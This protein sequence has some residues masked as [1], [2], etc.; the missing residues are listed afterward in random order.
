MNIGTTIEMN[1]KARRKFDKFHNKIAQS[2]AD[3]VLPNTNTN[4]IEIFLNILCD[5]V[6]IE[7][8]LY[9]NSFACGKIAKHGRKKTHT[10]WNVLT[11]LRHITEPSLSPY[12]HTHTLTA[13]KRRA[14]KTIL[15]GLFVCF[16]VYE[17]I[18]VWAC[19]CVY[20]KI[21]CFSFIGLPAIKCA[22]LSLA[23]ILLSVSAR[24]RSFGFVVGCNAIV[25]F[26]PHVALCDCIRFSVDK[27]DRASK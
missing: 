10:A 23:F 3:S 11:V 2:K 4:W 15:A 26:S 24:G 7:F 5:I 22:A 25:A 8:H 6:C 20:V 21:K 12:T 27:I 17:A 16:C 18:S 9:R 19:V 14:I 1:G 13:K